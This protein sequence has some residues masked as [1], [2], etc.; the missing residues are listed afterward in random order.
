[1]VRMALAG[2][3]CGL[4][5]FVSSSSFFFR[6][7]LSLMTR[8]AILW[9]MHQPF[10]EDLATGEHILPWVRLHAIKDYWGM[11]ALVREFPALRLT[12][13]LAP[14]LLVQIQ[15]FADDRASDRHLIVGLKEA[16]ALDA[17]E[18]AF[19]VANGFHAPVDRMIR[20]HPRYGE[21]HA[22]RAD[23]DSF[24]ADDL[25]DLQVL[26]KLAWMDPDWLRTDARLQALVGKQRGY[27]EGD[28][29][30]LRE[31]ELELLNAVIPVY[32]EL[33]ASGRVELSTSPFYHPILPL[34]CDSDTHLRA[35]PHSALPRRLFSHPGDAQEQIRRALTF[36]EQTF[37]SRPAGMWPSEGSVS[38]QALRLLA[39]EGVA[40]VAT[41]EEILA[42][43]TQRAATPD[44]LYRPY[45]V[46]ADELAIRCL[47]RDHAL[48]DAIGFVYQSWEPGAA[49]EDFVGR[50]Q[51]AA[52]RFTART[53]GAES[54]VV[55]VILDGENAWEHYAGGGRPF[56][57]ALYERLAH[58]AD[59]QTV[60]MA[61]AASAPP[62]ALASVFPGSWI[63][64]DFYIWAGH[65]DDHRAWGQLA[66][67]RAAL[68]AAVGSS[69]AARATALEE[70]LIAEGSDWFWWYGD[71][72]SSDQD[73]EFDDLFR[74]HLRNVYAALELTTPDD[75][76]STNI[77]TGPA[78]GR[79]AVRGLSSPVMDGR[80][81][82]Y[83]E[84]ADSVD[85][86]SSEVAGAMQ[87]V[88]DDLVRT[89][90]V[91]CDRTTV[92]LR[93]DGSELVRR[94]QADMV[95]LV[96]V[97]E[98][99]EPVRRLELAE[100]MRWAIA[101]MVELA[102]P[103]GVLG[104]Q[105]GDRVRLSVLVVD[106][107]GQTLERHPSQQPL[108]LDLPTRHLTAAHWAV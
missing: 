68:D 98:Q 91:A 29:A 69:P 107:A 30:I 76:Y 47:F 21:L 60:T 106:S 70:I 8:L 86:R 56:L 10:Y 13:N 94:L 43:T 105:A 93:L 40:W 55:T 15:A 28:K 3:L 24:T 103:I 7:P 1:M 75:L 59:I 50:V 12:F 33:A 99:P 19:L 77:T 27:D 2:R 82:H 81:T 26:H 22:R 78:S 88:S 96:L 38:D 16:T 58:A 63:N 66:A 51:E 18:R 74:R 53:D 72:H 23:P 41:D 20:P 48:S 71:D 97:V 90:R 64:G 37:G 31:V 80:L 61:E 34:V 39:S 100:P 101:D 108:D 67:A 35:H 9:H 4:C 17:T 45:E 32:R 57:R 42:R 95:R 89:L 6:L 84:W 62:R 54:P 102:V 104:A 36:H 65:P 14:S 46:R 11:A 44:A 79:V 52:R 83:G 25:R 92:Y 85:V 87:R 5:V 73:R 49:A